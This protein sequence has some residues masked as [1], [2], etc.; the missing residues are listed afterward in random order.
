MWMERKRSGEVE[1]QEPIRFDKLT[2]VCREE[3]VLALSL[4]W[5]NAV[6]GRLDA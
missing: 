1:S 2:C 5:D 6:D 3:S 4:D